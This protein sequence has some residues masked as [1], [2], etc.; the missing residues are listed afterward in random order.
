[1]RYQLAIAALQAAAS[2]SSVKAQNSSFSETHV[3]E[4]P[5]SEV[6]TLA[7]IVED[8][9][10]DVFT[11]QKDWLSPE[12]ALIYKV[13]LPIPPVKEPTKLVQFT[14]RCSRDVSN[15]KIGKSSVPS[16]GR[17]SG[18]MSWRSSL[19][20]TKSIPT[21]VPPLLLATTGCLLAPL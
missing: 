4:I 5:E 7:Q 6:V 14:E 12:Y 15:F 17:R 20:V 13:A 21:S 18:T 16:P 8:D 19:S 3:S 11:L 1:M 10:G 9:P 2:F